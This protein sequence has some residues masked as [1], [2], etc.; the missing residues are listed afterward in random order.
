MDADAL[1]GGSTGLAMRLHDLCHVWLPS[2][3]HAL[4]SSYGPGVVALRLQQL[5]QAHERA[6]GALAQLLALGANSHYR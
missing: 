6:P 1:R 5:A 2:A 3:D 4:R